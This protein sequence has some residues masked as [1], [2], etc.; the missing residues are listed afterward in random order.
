MFDIRRYIPDI[1]DEWNQFVARSKN[2][3]FLFDRRYM[4][5]HQDRFADHSIAFYLNG[6]IYAILP[7]H[8]K[9]QTLYSHQGLTYGGLVMDERCTGGRICQLF[10]ELNTFL[11]QQRIEKVV[12]K[13]IPSIYH[14]IP[15]EEDLYAMSVCCQARLVSRDL[16][17]TIDL[18]HPVKFP[19]SRKA[20]I[21]KAKAHDL[22]IRESD[23]VGTFWEILH[24][25]LA[26]RYGVAPVHT[27]EEI[28]LLHS[29]FPEN[30]KLY[31]AFDHKEPLG[32]AILYM[33]KQVA[34]VQYISAN[35]QGKE[36]GAIDLLFDELLHSPNEG[37]RYFDFG[38]ST[39]HDH[40]QLNL[41]L[42]FQKEGFGGRGLC[43]DTY[44]WNT[45]DI[46]T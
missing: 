37:I 19:E 39:T 21:R 44:E 27:K 35:R 36:W 25:N 13:A 46:L 5:Y 9:G 10:K 2:G 31:M 24:A 12:Y 20:G 23:D 38:K 40:T 16:S 26:E 22:T 1:A 6:H 7:A 11:Y 8:L 45:N 43:Y 3:T 18:D 32:G 33:T 28:Q 30:I 29:R 4:D 14:V 42:L 41:Q 15:S 17:S 34:H